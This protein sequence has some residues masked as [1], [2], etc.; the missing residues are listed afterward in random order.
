MPKF[1]VLAASRQHPSRRDPEA[2]L[3]SRSPAAERV[4]ARRLDEMDWTLKIALLAS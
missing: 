2:H 3:S 4:M 1:R